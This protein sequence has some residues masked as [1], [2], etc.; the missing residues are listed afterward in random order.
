MKAVMAGLTCVSWVYQYKF[1]TLLYRF[2]GQELPQLVER[3]TITESL[4]LFPLWQLVGSLANP[5]KVYDSDRLAA[6]F[7]LL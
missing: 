1:H 2:V 5:R 7:C 6:I 4:I 3:P